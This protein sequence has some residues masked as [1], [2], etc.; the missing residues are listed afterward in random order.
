MPLLIRNAD[1]VNADSRTLAD[2]WIEKETITAIGLNMQ[3]SP[4][5][6]VIDARGRMVFPGFIDPHVHI[7]LPFMA[8][9]AKDTHETGSI[10]ALVGGT[11]TYIEMVCPSRNDDALE[12]Y[13]LW[14]SKAEGN[15]A[16]DYTFHMA[17][18]RFDEGTEA[19]LREIVSDGIASF[20]IFLSY[21]NFFGVDDGE[22]Y[23]TLTLAKKLGVIVTAHCENAE[24]VARLQQMLLAAG[25]T[26]PE[27]HEPSRPESV[28]AEGTGRFAT[29]LENTGAAGYVVH[30]SSKGALDA[31]LAAKA[32]GV[33]IWVES[34]LPHFLLDKTYAERPG[35]EG[36]KHVM[37]PPLRDKRNQKY[38]WDALGQ[39]FIDT[40]GTD[41]CPF[42]TSQ[43]FMGKDAFTQIPNGIP[44]IEERVNLLYTYGVKRGTLGLHRFV[45]A[46]STR[47]AKLFG[48]FPRK[49]TIAVGSDA[50]LVIYDDTYRGT[51]TAAAQ[52]SNCDYSGFEGMEIEGRPHIVTVRG[53][54]QVRDGKFIGERGRGHLLKRSP[55]YF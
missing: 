37:S 27:Y 3:V 8:T 33:R 40:V 25:K 30:L 6:E 48:L 54:V 26:G 55:N 38:L 17:V 14:K 16:C 51:V 43:K 53:K 46:A 18:T 24:L 4:D 12:G 21:K 31:A 50:D 28:E 7:Y 10:A 23:Q 47:A 11:T 44:G 13:R 49:G 22:M 2:I 41:H 39:G 42:D 5:A 1:I 20:K 45:D 52:H 34:V 9:F 19:Q 35:V 36:M 15:S 29:F 32:R